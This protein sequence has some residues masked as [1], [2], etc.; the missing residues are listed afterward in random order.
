[1]RFR[2][3][4]KKRRHGLLTN[5]DQSW[6]ASD[7]QN[8]LRCEMSASQVKMQMILQEGILNY[9]VFRVEL[10]PKDLYFRKVKVELLVLIRELKQ[11]YCKNSGKNV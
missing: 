9:S 8:S 3:K 2:G 5:T 10:K 1:M 6:K 11:I 4:K 7:I